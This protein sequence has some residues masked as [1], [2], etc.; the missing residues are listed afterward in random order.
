M[1]PV[2][3]ALW[4]VESVNGQV[5]QVMS[6][7][8]VSRI[9]D[10]SE[11]HLVPTGIV[12]APEGGAYV[13]FLTS[14]PYPMGAAKVSHIAPNGTVTDVWTGLTTVTG[15]ALSPDGVLYVAELSSEISDVEPFLTPETGRIL[16][17]AGPDSAEEVIT[18]LD[19]PTAVRFGPDGALYVSAPAFGGDADAGRVIRIDFVSLAAA[20]TE[21]QATPVP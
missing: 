12:A 20:G 10:L 3:D 6:T 7:G 1:I 9:T 15:L 14:A 13:G 4:V 2:G 11:G 21:N 8:A 16:R 5:L 18:G 19:M 17:Q